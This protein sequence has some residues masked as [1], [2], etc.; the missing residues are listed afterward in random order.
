MVMSEGFSRRD[1]S[2]EMISSSVLLCGSLWNKVAQLVNVEVSHCEHKL[3]N[4]GRTAE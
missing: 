4:Q 3:D 1:L 2:S